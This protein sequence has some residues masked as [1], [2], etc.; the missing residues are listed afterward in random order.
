M[1]A[2]QQVAAT[3]GLGQWAGSLRWRLLAATLVAL[4]LALMLAGWVLGGLFR[5]HV[6]RQ[7]ETA[8]TLQLDQLTAQLDFDTLGQPVIDPT[9]LSDPR[10]QKPFSGLYWQID[11]ISPDQQTRDGVLRSRS[12]WDTQLTL[13]YDALEDG[14]IH[15]HQG[16]GPQGA[17]LMMIER[18]VRSAESPQARWRLVVAADLQ[19]THTAIES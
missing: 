12:L 16:T 11:R 10:W 9:S 4:A 1:N 14:A 8:L 19:S 5:E 13:A 17:R 15:V 2:P 6:M 3:Q 7:F 18:T